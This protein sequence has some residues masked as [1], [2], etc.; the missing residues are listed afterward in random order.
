MSQHLTESKLELPMQGEPV[1]DYVRR[2]KLQFPHPAQQALLDVMYGCSF[3]DKL[4]LVFAD[5]LLGGDPR[6]VNPNFFKYYAL[7][8]SFKRSRGVDLDQGGDPLLVLHKEPK[9]SALILLSRLISNLG[10]VRDDLASG[11]P[12][13]LVRSNIRSYSDQV[14]Y[15][16]AVDG[17]VSQGMRYDMLAITYT[18]FHQQLR[19]SVARFQDSEIDFASR[20]IMGFCNIEDAVG[21]GVINPIQTSVDF[22]TACILA[23]EMLRLPTGIHPL[24]TELAYAEAAGTY[25]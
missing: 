17:L 11:D 9:D 18:T 6:D 3:L 19:E 15:I 24:V 8:Q 1:S 22:T 12:E 13:I 4:G 2:L 14:P 23:S 21:T 20:T 7:S 25:K 16:P 10:N 5:R